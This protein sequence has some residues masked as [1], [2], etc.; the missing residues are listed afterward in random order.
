MNG[1]TP[2]E[3]PRQG[4]LARLFRRPPRE[5]AYFAIQ[6]LLAATAIKDLPDDAVLGILEGYR[7]EPAEA[8]A[9]LKEIYAT[10]L[11]HFSRDLELS[12]AEVA[13]LRRLKIFFDL[14]DA[15]VAEV[16]R[17]VL[18]PYYESTLAAM[19]E[20]RRLSA[21]ERARLEEVAKR[22]RL[23]SAVSERIQ[24]EKMTDL[25]QRTL[26]S[27]IA[28]RRLSPE[29]EAELQ[30]IAENL[31]AK[32][33]PADE[34]TTAA[35]DY[36]RLIWRLEQ[37][38][39]PV[40]ETHLHLRRGEV[41][42]AAWP[43]THLEFRKVTRSVRYGGP[44]ARVRLMP[45]VYYRIG[46]V[47]VERVAD[48]VLQPLDDGTLFL[49]SQRLIFNGSKKN[50]SLPCPKIL[51]FVVHADGLQIEKDTGRDLFFRFKG[52]ETKLPEL[53]G[54]M[55]SGAMKRQQDSRSKP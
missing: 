12:D 51:N 48:D 35:L 16:E 15:D 27:A 42:H 36:F 21:E 6:N 1:F 53:W 26:D 9:K 20:D 44:V 13:D 45:G 5:H 41:C 7:V 28:D 22:L 11:R 4:M 23:P 37:G 17:R 30:A 18:D 8:R 24:N 34:A 43:V 49:T 3:M 55:L 29:E 25:V 19:L 38:E 54:V 33:K 52:D 47:S 2:F 40:V 31:Q 46:E 10:V 32:L 50:V 14:S 39:L